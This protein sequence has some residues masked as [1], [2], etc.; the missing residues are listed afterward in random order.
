MYGLDGRIPLLLLLI[1]STG[2]AR[3]REE[4]IMDSNSSSKKNVLKKGSSLFNDGG[5]DTCT[6]KPLTFK[7]WT[8][9]TAQ[10]LQFVALIMILVSTV[11][12][13]TLPIVFQYVQVRNVLSDSL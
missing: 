13:F 10:G 4:P 8:G 11:I 9:K 3:H 12:L 1:I 5:R 7:I 6:M 2:Y